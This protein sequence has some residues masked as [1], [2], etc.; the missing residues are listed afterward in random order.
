L[1]IAVR[2][3]YNLNGMEYLIR[4]E[5]IELDPATEAICGE[6]FRA[7]ALYFCYQPACDLNGQ[8]ME[9][10]FKAHNARIAAAVVS[11]DRIQRQFRNQIQ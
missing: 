1:I 3:F 2:F 10:L 9:L 6:H 4:S 11:V 5:L 8:L 7:H